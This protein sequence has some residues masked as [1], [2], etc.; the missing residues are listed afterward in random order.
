MTMNDC[1]FL[2]TSG[3]FC[4]HDRNDFR[5]ATARESIVNAGQLLITNYV[6]AE[7][8]PLS[9]IRGHQ[10]PAA[11]SFVLDMLKVSRLR[12]IWVDMRIHNAAMDLLSDRLDK[13]YSLCD[14]VSFI[15]MREH[16][17]LAALTTDKHFEQAGFIRLLHG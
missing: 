12:L 4:L 10:R 7:F 3:L 2:D 6:L 16:N 9:Q 15:V 8:I 17:F 5:H 1:L 14:A 13:T 11:L